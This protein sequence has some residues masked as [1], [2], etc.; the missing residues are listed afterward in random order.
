MLWVSTEIVEG[1][2]VKIRAAYIKQFITIAAHLRTLNNF[3]GLKSVVCGLQSSAVRRL[4]KSW[5]IVPAK[6]RNTFLELETLMLEEKSCKNYRTLLHTV[7]PPCIPFLGVYLTDLTMIESG[8]S[9]TLA[10]DG[11]QLI[12]FHKRHLIA[13]VIHE[14]KRYQTMPYSLLQVDTIT[15]WIRRRPAHETESIYSRSLAVEPRQ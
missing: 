8:N 13:Q 4:R 7:N 15:Q 3:D 2:T 10:I 9:D 5:D 12:N 14:L 11:S 6:H 1:T